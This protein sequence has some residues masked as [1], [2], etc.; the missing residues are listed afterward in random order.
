[1][2]ALSDKE[3]YEKYMLLNKKWIKI[4]IKRAEIMTKYA[5]AV[6]KWINC[7]SSEQFFMTNPEK[8]YQPVIDK[9][10]EKIRELEKEI[11]IYK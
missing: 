10:E 7:S 8:E 1:M 11:E 9:Y 3:K 4:D 5:E 6:S 2:T